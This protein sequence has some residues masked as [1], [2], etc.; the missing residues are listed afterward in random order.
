LFS[1]RCAVEQAVGITRRQRLILRERGYEELFPSHHLIGVLIMDP[2]R[3]TT[4]V[5][6]KYDVPVQG[7]VLIAS[8][9]LI[10]VNVNPTTV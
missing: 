9:F 10:A 7:T 1:F 6:G 4:W 3:A 2:S 5:T 8:F